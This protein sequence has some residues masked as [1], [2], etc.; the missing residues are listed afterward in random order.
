MAI[1]GNAT[2]NVGLPNES[3]GS[4]SL[5]TA[6]TKV[7]NNFDI[8]FANAS[9]NVVAG[10][11]ISVSVANNVATVTNT[12]VLGIVQGAGNIIVSNVSGVYTISIGNVAAGIGTVTSVNVVPV[13]TSRI[14]STGGPITT[15]GDINL[16]LATTGVTAGTYTS[17][18]LTIDAYGRVTSATTGSGS[19]TVS[20]VGL[21]PGTGIQITG[22]PVTTSGNI[23]V[24]NTGVTSLSAGPGIALNASNG[25]VTITSLLSLSSVGTV[26]NV[27]IT[28][29]TLT[30]SGGPIS[31]FGTFNIEIPS[32]LSIP[33]NVVGNN[34]TSNSLVVNASLSTN[35]VTLTQ[36]GAG[37]A[38]VVEDNTSDDTP[39]V[40]NSFGYVITG[41]GTAQTFGSG[42]SP[43]VQITGLTGP[44]ESIFNYV[45]SST[46]PYTLYAK[47]R[48]DS[49]TAKTTVQDGDYLGRLYFQG[50]NTSDFLTGARIEASVDTAP[51]SS[52][53][54]PTKIEFLTRKAGT[55]SPSI[56]MTITN[57][58]STAIEAVD[59]SNAAL[60]VTQTG[61][62]P[63]FLVE[64]AAN[65]DA[66]PFLVDTS[67]A[68]SVGYTGQITAG[69]KLEVVDSE[70]SIYRYG[71]GTSAATMSYRKSSNNTVGGQG[72]VNS[73]DN[74]LEIVGYASDGVQFAR[75]GDIFIQVQDTPVSGSDSIPSKMFFRTTG[76][77][78]TTPTTRQ[79]I[80]DDGSVNFP[81]ILTL[82]GAE[83]LADGAAATLLETASYFTTGASGETA[84]LAAGVAGMIKTFMM[85]GDGGGD[86]VITVTN[87]GW[88][89]SGTG[90]MTFDTIGDS[91]ILQYIN[92]KWF[93]IGNNG[94]VFA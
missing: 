41:T 77:G 33:G 51:S 34:L 79:T 53:D 64:D 23:T 16:D 20:S 67:G 75:A 32:S 29:S 93:C 22:G 63:A 7:N 81:G 83:D 47:S 84:T 66:T 10:N 89:S 92:S 17:P 11:G 14:T 70:L 42:L 6:F 87:A 55:T 27:D 37:N 25:N 46:P 40:I 36:R 56:R 85:R 15:Y 68:V 31:T 91:C 61:T 8:L 86:M 49:I 60:R 9:P 30:V 88:K 3:T 90:T 94:V 69:C 65:P 4:D 5:Y 54:L 71:T 74:V 35:L 52:T 38:L 26:T 21:T 18:V 19:G 82:S 28:S 43:R 76:V 39:F 45:S 73:G 59:N 2:I 48:G 12:G 58:G 13:S 78:N 24:T 72:L 1:T 57:T 80:N 62:G 50:Y 44:G